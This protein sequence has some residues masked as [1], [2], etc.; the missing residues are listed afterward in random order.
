MQQSGM[1]TKE[2]PAATTSNFVGNIGWLDG[3]INPNVATLGKKH[4]RGCPLPCA[5][6]QLCVEDTFFYY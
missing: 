1:D 4:P 6:E 5:S 3:L 2:N